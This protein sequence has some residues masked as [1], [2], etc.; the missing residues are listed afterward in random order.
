ME[1]LIDELRRE[2]PAGKP[3]QGNF[4]RAMPKTTTELLA[5][6]ASTVCKVQLASILLDL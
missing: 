1:A 4:V 2:G 3:F 5:I 6:D